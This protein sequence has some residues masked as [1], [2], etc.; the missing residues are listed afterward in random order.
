MQSLSH[1]ADSPMSSHSSGA[2][3][4]PSPHPGSWQFDWQPSP[5]ST[6]PS[7]QPSTTVFT[8]PSPHSVGVQSASQ[9]GEP[10]PSSQVS[11]AAVFS[12]PSGHAGVVQDPRRRDHD[13]DVGTG[14]AGLA[15]LVADDR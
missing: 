4:M 3:T 7:S 10:D 5:S 1:M 12:T 14:E 2:T 11:P 9:V 13:V 15:E 6:L 8:K